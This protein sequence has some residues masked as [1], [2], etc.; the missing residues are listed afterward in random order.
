MNKEHLNNEIKLTIENTERLYVYAL[1]VVDFK[2][3][4]N[5]ISN[6]MAQTFRT[7]RENSQDEV[8]PY[9]IVTSLPE[10]KE[11]IIEIVKQLQEEAKS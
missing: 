11:L 5:Q 2:P 6:L 4:N 8:D 9:K 3:D 7:I 10:V 1:E